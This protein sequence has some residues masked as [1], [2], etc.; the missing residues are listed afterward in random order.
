MPVPLVLPRIPVLGERDFLGRRIVRDRPGVVAALGSALK[1]HGRVLLWDVEGIRNNR[2][3]LDLVKSFEGRG[4]WVNAGVRSAEGVIDV[5]VAGAERAVIDVST[6]SDLGQLGRASDLTDNLALCVDHEAPRKALDPT[7]EV[8]GIQELI[9]A[10]RSAGIST[11]IILQPRGSLRDRFGEA[12]KAKLDVFVGPLTAAE[13]K[14]GV[15]DAFQ[16]AVVD[17]GEGPWWRS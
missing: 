16:G 14:D 6:V 15:A 8:L 4:L 2:P 7:T 5:L 17:Q 9:E 10:G 12:R 13:V 1:E 3:R 11:A